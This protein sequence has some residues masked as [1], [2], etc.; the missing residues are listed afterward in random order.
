MFSII[1]G[2]RRMINCYGIIDIN[3]SASIM[4]DLLICDVEGLV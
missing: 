1:A 4:G 2:A 3:I